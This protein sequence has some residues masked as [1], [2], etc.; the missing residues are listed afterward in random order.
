MLC[1]RSTLGRGLCVKKAKD[2]Q[3]RTLSRRAILTS[4]GLSKGKEYGYVADDLGRGC[5]QV[6]PLKMDYE[7]KNRHF[8]SVPENFSLLT[9]NIWGLAVR[10]NLKRLFKL[11]KELLLRTL[12]D[13]NA[14]MMCFQEM[15]TFA[16]TEMKDYIGS[17]KFASEVPFP[18]N[19][20]VR[21]RSAEVY[22]MSRYTPKRLAVYGLPGVLSYENSMLVVEY[23]NLI[24]FN[25]YI[26]AGSKLSLGQEE[27]WIHYSRCRYDLLN[28]IYDMVQE[29]YRDLPIAVC[30]DFN[31]HQD[32]KIKDWPE[33]EI[34]QKFKRAQFID[35]F[36]QINKTSP[37]LTEDTDTNL[38]RWNQK[39]VEKKLRYDAILYRAGPI[40]WLVNSSK[41]IGQELERLSPED[42][43]WFYDEVSEANKMGGLERL[44]GVEPVPGHEEQFTLPINPSDHFGVLT[45]FKLS[46]R[47][48]RKM[49][50]GANKSQTR[51]L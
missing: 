4:E 22:F 43:K 13:V 39:L 24:I 5:Y 51:K 38:M 49:R 45:T 27:T 11:R 17:Y 26:Q 7:V 41:V 25:I 30:G 34:I 3:T 47:G 1:G 19:K 10:P 2:C 44:K 18:A 33:I 40:G 48:T 20:V 14:D 16:Y 46:N 42:S 21:N 6:P 35:T 23:P 28:I 8:D 29:K 31:F 9:Y 15:S 37:G 50:A 12:R 36:R 32:G